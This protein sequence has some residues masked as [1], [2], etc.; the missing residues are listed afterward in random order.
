MTQKS[1]LFLT[2]GAI[3]VLGIVMYVLIDLGRLHFLCP[4]NEITN[5]RCPS[6]GNTRALLSLMHGDIGKTI[7]HN[8]LFIPELITLTF[9]CFYAPYICIYDKEIPKAVYIFF[10]SAAVCFIIWGIIRNIFNI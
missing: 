1:K 7:K 6:C 10:V 9:L 5:L 4:I 2:Y 3:A 8:L